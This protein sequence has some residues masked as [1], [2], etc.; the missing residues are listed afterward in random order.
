MESVIEQRMVRSNRKRSDHDNVFDD[1]NG[2]ISSLYN[3]VENDPHIQFGI[4]LGKMIPMYILVKFLRKI[5]PE[6]QWEVG[7][8]FGQILPYF[9][10]KFKKFHN[11]ILNFSWKSMYF[12]KC[13][14][15]TYTQSLQ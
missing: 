2:K 11:K 15:T 6:P 12:K 8:F 5:I 10:D 4:L 3:G 14:S 9:E 7:R 13:Y 1:S